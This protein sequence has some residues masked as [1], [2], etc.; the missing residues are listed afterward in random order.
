MLKARLGKGKA[1]FVSNKP[2]MPADKGQ[3]DLPPSDRLMKKNKR[4]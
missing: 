4:M 1:P 2:P 3:F